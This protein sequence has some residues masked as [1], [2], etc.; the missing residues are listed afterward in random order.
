LKRKRR[1]KGHALLE[2]ALVLVIFLSFLIGTLDFA[3]FLYFHQSLVERVRAAARYGAVNPTDVTGIKNMAVYN[4]TTAAATPMVPGLTTSIVSVAVEDS[5]TPA[6]RVTVT[7]SGYPLQFFSPF[8][9]G[10]RTAQDI[11]ATM[12]TE[13]P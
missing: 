11:S 8:I 6:S 9:A 1:Q 4:S 2:S 12:I 7:V 3:Q 13:T 10:A 5:G